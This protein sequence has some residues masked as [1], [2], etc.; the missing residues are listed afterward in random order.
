VDFGR[1]LYVPWQLTTGKVLY[2]D[3]AYFNGPLSPY[4][5]SLWFRLFGVSITTLIFV[6][7]AI[8][9]AITFLIYTIFCDACDRTTAT[10]AS[11]TFVCVFGFSQHV[12]VG[13]Y[14]FVTPYSHELTHGIGFTVGMIFLFS[15]YVR[16]RQLHVI[17]LAGLFL[18]LVFLTKAEVFLAAAAAAAVGLGLL[19]VSSR[20]LGRRTGVAS[21]AFVGAT[22]LPIASFIAFLSVQMSA[23]QALRG[24]AGTW[25]ALL[26]S[27]VTM[28]PFYRLSM[29]LSDP[30]TNLLMM[31]RASAGIALL[32]GAVAVADAARGLQKTRKTVAGLSA[33]LV[34]AVALLVKQVP[35]PW[36]P[37]RQWPPPW[38]LI[39][40][41]LPFLTLTAGAAI[42]T[43]CIGRRAEHQITVRLLPLAMWAVLSFVL[44]GKIILYPRLYHYGFALAMPATLLLVALSVWLVPEVLRRFYGRGDFFRRIAVAMVL[45]D[46]VFYLFLSNMYY[47]RKDYVVGENGDAIL[48]YGPHTDLAGIG[49]RQALQRIQS[50]M[51]PEATFVALPE[52]VMLNYL[53]RRSNPTPYINF[54]PPEMS[55]FGEATI[56]KSFKAQPPDFIL[57]VHK[58]TSEY[59]VGYFGTDPGYGRQIMEWVDSHYVTEERVLDEPLRDKR[60][61]IKILKRRS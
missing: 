58:E 46:I 51:S 23:T 32:A 1:E 10:T 9:A 19:E 35:V 50:L 24:V 41:P 60:F 38:L 36:S 59:G 39:G 47:S 5:N 2:V 54:M 43:M 4:L 44:L 56:L 37:T 27:N 48:T 26:M 25:T 55:M 57:L 7:L 16:Y 13:N 61:G 30:G 14:N 22:L 45:A 6:N 28:N 8:L 53:S 15:R 31:V 3:I 49:T 42:T 17:I 18:G 20:S 29:G 21:L 52:G 33:L 34:A 40:W 12:S 11:L